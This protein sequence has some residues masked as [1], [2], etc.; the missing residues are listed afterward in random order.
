MNFSQCIQITK[1]ILFFISGIISSDS[2]EWKAHDPQIILKI[3]MQ[4]LKNELFVSIN[5]FQI[6][7]LFL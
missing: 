1:V 4:Y 2:A 6:D 5:P 3:E 7:F